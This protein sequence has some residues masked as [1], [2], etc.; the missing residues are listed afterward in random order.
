MFNP[1]SLASDSRICRV[2]FGVA[3]NAAFSVSSCFALIVVR[4]PLRFVPGVPELS[5]APDNVVVPDVIPV[6]PLLFDPMFEGGDD[7]HRES[8]PVPPVIPCPES[9]RDDEADRGEDLEDRAAVVPFD[10][11]NRLW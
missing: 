5:S 6:G 3:A 11:G 7:A 4:G 2:G 8:V 1:V 9:D 10:P